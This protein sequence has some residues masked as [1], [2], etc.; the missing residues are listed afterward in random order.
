VNSIL[1]AA[2]DDRRALHARIM[3]RGVRRLKGQ[4]LAA[5]RNVCCSRESH[6]EAFSHRLTP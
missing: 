1:A 3:M 4:K 6:S 2:Q 5:E